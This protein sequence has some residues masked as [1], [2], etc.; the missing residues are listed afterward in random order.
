M[1]IT[2]SFLIIAIPIYLMLIDFICFRDY[3]TSA[4]NFWI[5]ILFGGIS[6]FITVKIWNIT[7]G[8]DY[9][10]SISRLI[11]ICPLLVSIS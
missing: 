9:I 8:N 6:T 1:I 5:P 3:E 2:F 11:G 10:S 4:L 7:E